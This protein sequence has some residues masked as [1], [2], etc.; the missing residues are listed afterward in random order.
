MREE[1]ETLEVLPRRESLSVPGYS[2]ALLLPVAIMVVPFL[3]VLIPA[4]WLSYS[5]L[6]GPRGTWGALVVGAYVSHAVLLPLAAGLT[7][8]ARERRREVADAMMAFFSARVVELY[9]L[10]G[11]RPGVSG[12]PR[13]ARVFELYD[14]AGRRIEDDPHDPTR[15]RAEIEHG[16]QLADELLAENRTSS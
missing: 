4:L 7:V 5:G 15:A 12:D 11:R 3:L 1:T 10:C 2:S 8:R 9:A 14:Q 6:I 16:V 13:A